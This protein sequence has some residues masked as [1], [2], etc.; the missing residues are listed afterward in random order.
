VATVDNTT[1]TITPS[2]T[3]N[4]MN[5]TNSYS[6]NLLQGET[7]QISSYYDGADDT[8]TNDVTGTRITSDKPVAVFA[9]ASLAN[10][11]AEKYACANPLVQEQMPVDSWG[12][13]ALAMGF[14]GRMNGDSYRVLTATNNTVVSTNGVAA[15]T[16]QAG[17][18]LDLLIE[19]P[20][21]FQGSQPI[22]VAHFANG[23]DFDGLRPLKKAV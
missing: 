21:Q 14:A 15:G 13:Q 6:T 19:G 9:G 23:T 8:I 17:H 22:Q 10:V 2:P 5:H 3:A 4:L 18:F 12:T 20:V 7:Y 11:P 16:I 1:V